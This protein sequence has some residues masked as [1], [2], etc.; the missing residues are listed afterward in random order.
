[1]FSGIAS[2]FFG[3]AAEE[4]AGSPDVKF[5]VTPVDDEWA[6]VDRSRGRS[7]SVHDSPMEN[8]LIERPTMSVY[9]L[10]VRPTSTGSDA[11][12][13]RNSPATTKE[14]KIK[15]S[16]RRPRALTSRAGL[17]P[18]TELLKSTQQAKLKV[19]VKS[20]TRK[21]LNRYN[22]TYNLRDASRHRV[23]VQQPAKYC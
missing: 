4:T 10:R 14:A 16:P 22:K 18:Q 3:S 21:H 7:K 9:N 17:L 15:R 20:G 19:S 8:L 13:G 12:S 2:Y 1:M 6:L 23:R 5:R 11:G